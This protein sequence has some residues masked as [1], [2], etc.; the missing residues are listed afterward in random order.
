MWSNFYSHRKKE[1]KKK[2]GVSIVFVLTF[3]TTIFTRKFVLTFPTTIFS[4]EVFWKAKLIFWRLLRLWESDLPLRKQTSR[5]HK[6][7]FFAINATWSQLYAT[8]QFEDK[9][10]KF[11]KESSIVEGSF[12]FWIPTKLSGS[13]VLS[14]NE[15]KMWHFSFV[16][17]TLFFTKSFWKAKLIYCR[18]LSLWGSNL[19][20]SEQTWSCCGKWFS[21][22]FSPGTKSLSPPVVQ[23]LTTPYF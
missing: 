8:V 13:T 7:F 17:L 3:P 6:N 2:N 23:G 14:I 10:R 18:L 5:S 12:F 21:A 16:F 1:T 11:R 22:N 19:I 15:H 20:L 4:P 9:N